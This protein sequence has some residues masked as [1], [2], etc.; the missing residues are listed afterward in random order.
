[1]CW[2]RLIVKETRVHRYSRYLYMRAGKM[3]W[4]GPCQEVIVDTE[5]LQNWQTH[6]QGVNRSSEQITCQV[7][8]LRQYLASGLCTSS[9]SPVSYTHGIPDDS[10]CHD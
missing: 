2:C 3:V 4:Q 6:Q 5:L 7:Q 8:H 9:S 10:R 1:M